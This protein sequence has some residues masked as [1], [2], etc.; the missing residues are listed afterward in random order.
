MSPELPGGEQQLEIW[1]IIFSG[2][3]AALVS[4][5]LT[6]LIAGRQYRM[7]SKRALFARLMAGRS[8]PLPPAF[9]EALNELP[10][11]FAGDKR[12][13][14][15]WKHMLREGQGANSKNLINVLRETARAAGADLADISD[16]DLV[17]PF[18]PG[19]ENTSQI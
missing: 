1:N 18:V 9:F 5:L 19:T 4:A 14:D 8:M 7:Q 11:T 10:A 15:A 12:V 13:T 3:L 2:V 16:D 17:K 6:W